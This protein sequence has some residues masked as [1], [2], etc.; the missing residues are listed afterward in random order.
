E[1][2]DGSRPMNCFDERARAPPLPVS[3]P[4]F[5]AE[6]EKETLGRRGESKRRRRLRSSMANSSRNSHSAPLLHGQRVWPRGGALTCP[7]FFW[8]CWRVQGFC[9]IAAGG[10]RTQAG[11]EAVIRR[12][13]G[14]MTS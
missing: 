14:R 6:R 10:R 2:R 12:R 3:L 1:Q 13:R 7:K 5:M 4:H 8:H 9:P 11:R